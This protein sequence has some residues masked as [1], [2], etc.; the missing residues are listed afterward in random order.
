MMMWVTHKGRVYHSATPFDTAIGKKRE[1][2]EYLI[3]FK[4]PTVLSWW[5]NVRERQI[6]R[7]IDRWKLGRF[8]GRN[9]WKNRCKRRGKRWH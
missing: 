4:N 3:E 5:C 2:H 8:V 7:A 6:L 1:A 9:D